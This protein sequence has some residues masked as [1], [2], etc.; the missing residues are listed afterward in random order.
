MR[1]SEGYQW[2]DGS[3]DFASTSFV[4]VL[5]EPDGVHELCELLHSP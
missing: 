5:A 3:T 1:E 2:R 4:V